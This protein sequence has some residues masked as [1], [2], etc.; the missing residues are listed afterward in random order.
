MRR[1]INQR[2]SVAGVG[3]HLGVAC[4]LDFQPA[5]SGSGIRFQRR[6]L[7]GAAAIPALAD[8]AVLTERRTQLRRLHRE[9]SERRCDHEGRR[10]RDG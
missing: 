6:D 7:S 4:T 5:P 8:H 3:L 1:T 2:T 9:S 10:E